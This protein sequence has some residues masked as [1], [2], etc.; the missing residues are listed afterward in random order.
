MDPNLTLAEIRGFDPA[1]DP[2]MIKTWIAR[3]FI[4]PKD[5]KPGSGR[6]RQFTWTE[7]VKI[8]ALRFLQ[9]NG[10]GPKINVQVADIIESRA[11]SKSFHYW[12]TNT[13]GDL[14][15]SHILLYKVS[16]G[17][18]EKHEFLELEYMYV[19]MVDEI[20]GSYFMADQLISKVV[21]LI[22]FNIE[23]Y[24]VNYNKYYRNDKKKKSKFYRTT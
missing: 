4:N 17:D 5:K 12:I 9:N 6:P 21:E 11:K 13:F 22:V 14:L 7:I 20:Y 10:T 19:G 8:E 23:R 3:E 24:W 2:K 15:K 16:N 1:V 18:I